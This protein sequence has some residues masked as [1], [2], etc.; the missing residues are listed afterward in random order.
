MSQDRLVL[1]RNKK[2]GEEIYTTKNKKKNPKLSLKKYSK[3]LRK[4][5]DFTE[6]K[7]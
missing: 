5:V 2:T 7:K 1:L 4:R 3:K 6:A